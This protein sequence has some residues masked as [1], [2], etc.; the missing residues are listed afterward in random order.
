[1]DAATSRAL[2]EIGTSDVDR[3]GPVFGLTGEAL[4]NRMRAAALAAGLG[5]WVQRAQRQRRDGP[6]DGGGRSPQH[7]C[8]ATG[9]WKHGKVV[10]R[11]LHP[12]RSG[13]GGAEVAELTSSLSE[14]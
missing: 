4:V 5:R 8:V 10:A 13:G 7:R 12:G 9:P 14:G 6:L 3:E 11:P 2:R 1:M